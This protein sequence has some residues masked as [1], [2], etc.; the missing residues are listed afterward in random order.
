LRGPLLLAGAANDA[1]TQKEPSE[2]RVVFRLLPNNKRQADN[3]STKA[4]ELSSQ[5]R[6]GST[7]IIYEDNAYGTSLYRNIYALLK[8]KQ[9]IITFLVDDSSTIHII[10][11]SLEKIKDRVNSIIYL[12]YAQRAT[13]LLQDLSA[14]GL[15]LPVI[16]SDGCYSVEPDLKAVVSPPLSTVLLSFPVNPWATKQQQPQATSEQGPV[17]PKEQQLGAT[18]EQ[19]LVGFEGYGYNGYLLLAR[20]SNAIQNSSTHSLKEALSSVNLP[21][22]VHLDGFTPYVFG[23]DGEPNKF[24]FQMI[25]VLQANK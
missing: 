9:T 23:D 24:G 4:A 13:D 19:Q 8:D 18:K 5:R 22:Q 21:R 25:D 12:G 1:L 15:N 17:A 11:P 20:L 16:L 3:I 2:K 7:V 6:K 10:M 14:Y